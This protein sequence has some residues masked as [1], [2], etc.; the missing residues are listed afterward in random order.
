M[1]TF[2]LFCRFSFLLVATKSVQIVQ[3]SLGRL[4]IIS[5]SLFFWVSFGS[6]LFHFNIAAVPNQKIHSSYKVD[7]P[8]ELKWKH[9]I[10]LLR[11]LIFVVSE[12]RRLAI[13]ARF[14]HKIQELALLRA[15]DETSCHIV[16][17]CPWFLP[18]DRSCPSPPA[19]RKCK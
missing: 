3:F 17:I 11:L 9:S 13:L 18:L 4:M 6:A 8:I 14:F 10:Y 1:D 5:L 15:M 7:I 19:Y 2:R 16:W 12:Q